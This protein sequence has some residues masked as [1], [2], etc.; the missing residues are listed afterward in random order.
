MIDITA[1]KEMIEKE[2]LRVTE[3]VSTVKQFIKQELKSEQILSYITV[4]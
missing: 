1:I 3:W 2:G 4:G